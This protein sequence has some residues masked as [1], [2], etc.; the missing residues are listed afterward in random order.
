MPSGQP[1]QKSSK[2]AVSAISKEGPP[3]PLTTA[4]PMSSE[5]DFMSGMSSDDD[6]LQE[7]DNEEG[8]ADGM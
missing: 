5:D 8:S 7:S 3:T 1:V 2:R 4:T 6:M